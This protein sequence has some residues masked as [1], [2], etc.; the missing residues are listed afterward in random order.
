MTD[1]D[2][3]AAIESRRA[4]LEDERLAL[5]ERI[6]R[7]S[8]A[9]AALRGERPPTRQRSSYRGHDRV[10]AI[11][12]SFDEPVTAEQIAAHPDLDIKLATVRTLL[13]DLRHD[14]RLYNAV[15]NRKP[16]LWEP[17]QNGKEAGP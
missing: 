17:M 3:I 6:H 8:L 9:V 14:G 1:Y 7:M 4:E 2:L 16:L 13:T 5:S 10:Y 12:A 15:P 11:V